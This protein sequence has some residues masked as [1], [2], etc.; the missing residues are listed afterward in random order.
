MPC[1]AKKYDHSPKVGAI[2]SDAVGN[3]E[4]HPFFVKKAEEAIASRSDVSTSAF[5]ARGAHDAPR[6]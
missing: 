6:A 5:D 3:Y 4:K 1:K 2:V